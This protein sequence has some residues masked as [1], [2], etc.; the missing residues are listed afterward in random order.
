MQDDGTK[1][2]L[3]VGHCGPDA[4]ALQSAVRSMVPGASVDQVNS[5]DALERELAD[6]GVLL[7]NRVLDGE[8]RGDSGLELIRSLAEGGDPGRAS[9][10]AGLVL[11]SNLASA[12]EEAESAGA[13]PGFGK[14]ELYSDRMRASLERALGA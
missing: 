12:Q 2:V 8:F 1:R 4:F 5:I 14:Q 11:I 3:L 9:G 13:L 7:I 6:A 10:G